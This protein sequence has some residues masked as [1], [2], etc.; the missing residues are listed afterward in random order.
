MS[1]ISTIDNNIA[2]ISDISRI[3]T[4]YIAQMPPLLFQN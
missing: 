2:L 4:I 3:S 1:Q